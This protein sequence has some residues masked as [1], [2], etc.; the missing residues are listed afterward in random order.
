MRPRPGPARSSASAGP[1]GA[2]KTTVG[3]LVAAGGGP[4]PRRPRQRHDPAGGGLRRLARHRRRPRRRP[5]SRPCARR[6][7]RCLGEVVADNLRAGPWRW[8]PSHRSAAEA[9]DAVAWR[10][11]G[12]CL[13][14]HAGRAGAGSTSSPQ[15]GRRA[16][17]AARGLPRDLAKAGREGGA[18][19]DGH[20]IPAWSTGRDRPGARR[21]GGTAGRCRRGGRSCYDGAQCPHERGCRRPGPARAGGGDLHRLHPGDVV[22][23]LPRPRHPAVGAAPAQPAGAARRAALHRAAPGG[24]AVD[25]AAAARAALGPCA[26][27][28]RRPRRRR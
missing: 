16:R 5:S 6:A 4:L 11:L 18:G 14:C 7:T 22:R 17:A 24:R 2:G 3:A 25:E 8:W 19:G 27:G 13:G 20:G 10:E 15:R 23:R 12:R 21:V 28:R 1:P 26:A 9:A